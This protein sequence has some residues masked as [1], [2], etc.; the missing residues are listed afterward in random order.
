MASTQQEIQQF[1]E[2]QFPQSLQHCSII[3]VA[4]KSAYVRYRIDQNHLRPGGTVSGPTIMAIADFGLYVAILAEL[5]IV[6][7]AVTSNINIHFLNKPSGERDLVAEAK[8]I[9]IGRT[10]IVGE[11]WV[12]SEGS[13]EPVAQV[14]GSYSV[15]IKSD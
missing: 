12:Y 15:P 10:L 4:E 2:S 7:M 9:K 3:S 1:L 5:G 14:T 11:V 8:L 6:A 13:D